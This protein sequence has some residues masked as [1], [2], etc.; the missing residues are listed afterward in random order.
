M[1]K[2]EYLYKCILAIFSVIIVLLLC[3]LTI[4]LFYPVKKNYDLERWRY[5]LLGTIFHEKPHHFHLH[6]PNSYFKELYGV[7]VKI[8]S[9]GLRDFEYSYLKPANIYRVLVLG[10]SITFGWGVPFEYTY[11]KYLEKML[12]TGDTNVKFQVINTGVGNYN[13]QSEV[14][15]L[16]KEGLKYN[17]DMIVLGYFVNDAQ[18]LK[19]SINFFNKHS[20][21]Y[22][23]LWSKINTLRANYFKGDYVSY[24]RL[25]YKEGSK[26]KAQ[27]ETSVRELK[28]IAN[29][30]GIPLLV[31]LLPD[32]HDLKKYVFKDINAYVQHL[33]DDYPVVD[34]LPYFDADKNPVYYWVSKEDPHYNKYAHRLIA[35]NL[36]PE[37]I[38]LMNGNLKR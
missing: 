18:T 17:P 27:F 11:P 34:M 24:Y 28:Q 4:R 19:P 5:A 6:K 2:R 21:L 29:K 20:Y 10:D 26:S 23:Y 30:T 7:E 1:K 9:K 14:E 35:E 25:F 12:N 36:Y 15:F 8:N 38:K 13:T 31:V 33:F 37:V 3:E 16:K 22:V 32:L